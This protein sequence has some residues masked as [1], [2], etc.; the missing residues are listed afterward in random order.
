MNVILQEADLLKSQANS[1]LVILIGSMS[2]HLQCSLSNLRLCEI[3]DLALNMCLQLDQFYFLGRKNNFRMEAHG[4]YS[5][6][7]VCCQL[8]IQGKCPSFTYL[9]S[10]SVSYL[11]LMPIVVTGYRAVNETQNTYLSQLGEIGSGK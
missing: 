6:A 2:F 3:T 11:M 7:S 5:Q 10:V 4:R 8:L 9:R 1:C